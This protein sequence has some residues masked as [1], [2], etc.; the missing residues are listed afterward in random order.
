M[1]EFAEMIA[2]GTSSAWFFI[3]SAILLGALHGLE[4]GHSKT[5]MAAFIVAIRGTVS[6]AVLLGVAATA[7][8]TLIVWIVALGGLYVYQGVD[9]EA[10]EPYL[11]LLSA[12][13]IIGMALW[14]IATAYRDQQA[15]KAA[16]HAHDGGHGHTHHHDEAREL[17]TGH[18]VVRLEIFEI[19]QPPHW[20]LRTLSGSGWAAEDV[21]VTIRRPGG[22]SQLFHFADRGAYLESV[23]EIPEP[24][25]FDAR[26]TLSR[27]GHGHECDLHFAEGADHHHVHEAGLQL[28]D[29][30]F[31]DAH[32][33]AHANDIRR[34]F[35]GR[36]ATNWQIVVFGL[37]GGLLPCPA[38]VTVLLICLQLKEIAL[39]VVLV[40]CFSIGL[41]ITLVAVGAAA[42]LA[43]QQLTKRFTWLPALAARAPYPS[44]AIIILVGLYVGYSGYLGMAETR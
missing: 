15:A 34:E 31:Q 12:V 44:G 18:G 23:D 42:A 40:L 3:P 38:A 22:S 11:Q 27:G 10:V 33:I 37:T 6:Q 26:L 43:S 32:Q 7:S 19:G 24:H 14:M 9:A 28:A 21:A 4:P 30:G 29:E 2:R 39:G 16:A 13:I 20:R 17:R 36:K 35:A 1:T 41:A 5:M 25:E 8:H